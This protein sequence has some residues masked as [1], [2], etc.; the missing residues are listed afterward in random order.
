E[1]MLA[2]VNA[3]QRHRIHDGPQKEQSPLSV[4]RCVGIGLTISL[5]PRSSLNCGA[6]LSSGT[7]RRPLVLIDYW[8]LFACALLLPSEP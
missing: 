5:K 3:D 6:F 1:V 2:Q 4:V 8:S 7:A